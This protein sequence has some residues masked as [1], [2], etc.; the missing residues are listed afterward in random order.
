MSFLRNKLAINT[1]K[2][3][4]KAFWQW[5][6]VMDELFAERDRSSV[7][8]RIKATDQFTCHSARHWNYP[9]VADSFSL[10]HRNLLYCSLLVGIRTQVAQRRVTPHPVVEHFDIVE[11]RYP[12]RL[13]AG[14]PMPIK[15]LALQA[16]HKALGDGV[17]QR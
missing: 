9:E 5:V 15:Q 8:L 2:S 14:E 1:T 6:L 10:R 12:G 11:D 16:R 3:K 17:I 7:S 4:A 13:P